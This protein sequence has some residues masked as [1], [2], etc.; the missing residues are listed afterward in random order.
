MSSNT[1]DQKQ[2]L[3]L[4]MDKLNR[5]RGTIDNNLIGREPA[6]AKNDGWDRKIIHKD[7]LMIAGIRNILNHGLE[8]IKTKDANEDD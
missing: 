5:L 4:G 6:Q 1:R 2:T 3:W 7:H 8:M